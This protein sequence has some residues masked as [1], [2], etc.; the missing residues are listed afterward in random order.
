MLSQMAGFPSFLLQWMTLHC[1]DARFL[2]RSSSAY[3]HLGCLGVLAVVN[4][5]AGVVI[6]G[7]VG[8]SW[9]QENFS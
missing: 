8:P 3:I 6:L 5:A 1:L 9:R 7:V 4:N 2:I